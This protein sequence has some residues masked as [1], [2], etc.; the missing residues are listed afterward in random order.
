MRRLIIRDGLSDPRR[1]VGDAEKCGALDPGP[2]DPAVP[3]EYK[4]DQ[5]RTLF[6][7][8]GF[9]RLTTI[10]VVAAAV[11]GVAACG[12]SSSSSTKSTSTAPATSAT[13]SGT[14]S[15]TTSGS[16]PAAVIGRSTSVVVN[17]AITAALKHADI[18]IAAVSPASTKTHKTLLIFPTSS[19]QI[20]TATVT[21]TV[22]DTGGLTFSHAGKSVKLTNFVVNTS[23]K[24]LTAEVG[25]QQVVVF[26]LNLASLKRA[27]GPKGTVVASNI[28]L[29]TT[30]QLASS[31]NSGLGVTTFK[32]GQNFGIL[33]LTIA[34][35]P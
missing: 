15:A 21:G 20:A 1:I 24:E 12:S 28:K 14:P 2:D 23:T 9:R 11:L 17:P 8:F 25:G 3:L 13:T 29:T 31:L 33:T 10:G 5:R 22:N 6:M 16:A 30:P 32:G 19:G 7:I 27:S 26:D 34:V 35:K 18:T 4:S